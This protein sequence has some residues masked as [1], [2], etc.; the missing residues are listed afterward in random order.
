VHIRLGV[1]GE[2]IKISMRFEVLD[3]E[4]EDCS[5]VECNAMYFCR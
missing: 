5:L 3:C 2:N 4:C 1:Q